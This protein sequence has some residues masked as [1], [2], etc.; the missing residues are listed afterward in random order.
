VWPYVRRNK[1][2]PHRTAGRLEAMRCADIHP[3]PVK[4]PDR[5][6]VQGHD[7]LDVSHGQVRFR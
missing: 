7:I 3:V 1:N 5:P 2:G 6:G 4:A